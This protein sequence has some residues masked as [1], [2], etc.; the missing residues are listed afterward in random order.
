MARVLVCTCE[1]IPCLRY[2]VSK[3]CCMSTRISAYYPERA[4]KIFLINV[5]GVFSKC[6]ALIKPVSTCRALIFHPCPHLGKDV[7]E[8]GM[9]HARCCSCCSCIQGSRIQK[10]PHACMSSFSLSPRPVRTSTRI[11]G[12]VLQA[13]PP[14]CVFLRCVLASSECCLACKIDVARCAFSE[15]MSTLALTRTHTCTHARQQMLDQATQKK[16]DIFAST[17]PFR[18]AIAEVLRLDPKPKP[19]TPNPKI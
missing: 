12:H 9:L 8:E 11:F 1:C 4:G 15:H 17:E 5:P 7:C 16:V 3:S 13:V 14:A 19:Q 6:W 18:D 2:C 10:D